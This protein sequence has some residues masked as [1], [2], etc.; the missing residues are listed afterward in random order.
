[1]MNRI[2]NDTAQVI[3]SEMLMIAEDE[4]QKDITK[5]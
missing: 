2:H 1:M 5:P 3:K 4:A